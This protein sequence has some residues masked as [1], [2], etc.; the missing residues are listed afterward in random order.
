MYCSFVVVVVGGGETV[1]GILLELVLFEIRPHNK[2]VRCKYSYSV[3]HETV[4]SSSVLEP[5]YIFFCFA[6]RK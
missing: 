1:K 6:Q 4:K 5:L 2:N 3:C